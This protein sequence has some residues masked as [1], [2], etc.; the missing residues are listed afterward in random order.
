MF[1]KCVEAASVCASAGG[2]FFLENP[3]DLGATKDGERPASFWQW[4]RVHDLQVQHHAVTCAFF[5][6]SFG[7]LT[8]KPSRF[9]CNA[10]IPSSTHPPS[11]SGPAL[12]P[13]AATPGHSRLVVPTAITLSLS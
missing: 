5:R 10:R 4:P 12:I 6:C 9:L 7:A 13:R 1:D 11:V 3:E 8:A 2:C